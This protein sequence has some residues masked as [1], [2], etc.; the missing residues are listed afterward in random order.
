MT[1]IP[2]WVWFA[3]LTMAAQTGMAMIN[4]YFKVRAL[5]MLWWMRLIAII[6]LLPFMHFY[7]PPAD[8]WFYIYVALGAV[9]FC[10][11]DLV[12]FGLTAKS[13]AGVVTRIGPLVVAGTFVLWTV[14]T[15][16]LV[17]GY[18]E[19][20][21]RTAG[22]VVALAGSV[23]FSIRMRD[24]PVSWDALKIMAPYLALASVGMC[25]G[26]L[27]MQHAAP[28]EGVFYYTLLQS[29]IVWVLYMGMTIAPA[30]WKFV[31]HLELQS[32]FRDRRVFYA[33]LCAAV[34]W[35]VATPS[36]WYAISIVENPAYVSTIS[37]CE[38]FAVLLIYRLLQRREEARIRDG[39]G[40]V[41][42][43]IAL[44]VFTQF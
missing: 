5:H 11:F 6:A 7:A 1:L 42:C 14:I 18:I 26:K 35:I 32:S 44:V 33:G 9:I 38:P 34:G 23:F 41:A 17:A 12:Y 21:L 36:K 29:V 16:S 13:G 19:S 4:E 3:L 2:V 43:A 30:S 25:L 20:P 31:P 40:I 15:P 10:W 37:L 22:I 39:I 24:C 27:A 8:P 28:P